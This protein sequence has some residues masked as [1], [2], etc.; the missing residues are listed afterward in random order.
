[1]AGCAVL[2]LAL[3]PVDLAGMSVIGDT[4]IPYEVLSR[5]REGVSWPPK[6]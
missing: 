6:P 2:K 1:M 4:L 3:I 5:H